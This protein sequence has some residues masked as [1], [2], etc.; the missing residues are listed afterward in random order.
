[1]RYIQVRPHQ[2]GRVKSKQGNVRKR[3]GCVR[4]TCHEDDLG[5]LRRR[6]IQ[7]KS[8]RASGENVN[9]ARRHGGHDDDD[10]E[11]C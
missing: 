5:G 9:N 2:E 10:A 7:T 6:R 4:R 1:M 8:A 3:Q 11:R